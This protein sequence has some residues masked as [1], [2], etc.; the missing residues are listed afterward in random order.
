MGV[1]KCVGS[2]EVSLALKKVE[3]KIHVNKF[4]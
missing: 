3:K 4:N 2:A 1:L